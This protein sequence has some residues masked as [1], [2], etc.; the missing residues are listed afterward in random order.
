MAGLT[1]RAIDL[2]HRD[3]GAVELAGQSGAIRAGAFDTDRARRCRVNATSRPTA[4]SRPRS[5]RTVRHRAHRRGDRPRRRRAHRH[6]YRHRQSRGRVGLYDGHGHPFLSNGFKGWHALAGRVPGTGPVGASPEP[7]P[8]RPV[9]AVSKPADGSF[10]GQPNGVSRFESQ[11]DPETEPTVDTPA[12]ADG[13]CLRPA[14]HPHHHSAGYG[15]RRRGLRAD[16]LCVLAEHD[17]IARAPEGRRSRMARVS[18]C[19]GVLSERSARRRSAVSQVNMLMPL[20]RRLVPVPYR[21]ERPGG[22]VAAGRT[23]DLWSTMRRMS[24]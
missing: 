23:S 17:D 8:T 22:A 2:D 24:R 1:V 9:S 20:R 15:A 12:T 18:T 14:H 11:T 4:D 3:A 13:G 5:C 10:E 7:F 19:V 6:G 21:S 16:V